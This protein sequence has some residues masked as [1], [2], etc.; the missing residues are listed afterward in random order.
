MRAKA[1]HQRS[2]TRAALITTVMKPNAA[3]HMEQPS[4]TTRPSKSPIT[5]FKKTRT[6][7]NMTK[8]NL[9][10]P[11]NGTRLLHAGDMWGL[12]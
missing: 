12:S 4:N 3:K 9:T 1:Q 11:N 5:S 2:D 8:Q 7:N 6:N 10:R